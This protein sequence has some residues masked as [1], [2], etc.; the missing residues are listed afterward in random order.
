MKIARRK[1]LSKEREAEGTTEKN[2]GNDDL[3]KIYSPDS[4]L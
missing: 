1:R 3:K 4:A 2:G